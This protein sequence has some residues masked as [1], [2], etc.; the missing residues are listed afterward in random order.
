MCDSIYEILLVNAHLVPI[1]IMES[2]SMEA[3]NVSHAI[4]RGHVVMSVMEDHAFRAAQA[5][6]IRTII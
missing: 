5:N 6:F 1:T 4:R 2:I 3:I